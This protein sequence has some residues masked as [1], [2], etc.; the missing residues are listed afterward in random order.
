MGEVCAP[1]TCSAVA[2]GPVLQ[3]VP[4]DERTEQRGSGVGVGVR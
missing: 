2:P 4:G 3:Q 1:P